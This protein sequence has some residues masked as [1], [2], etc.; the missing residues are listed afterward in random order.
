VT[1]VNSGVD[2]AAGGGAHAGGLP[3]RSQEAK[4]RKLV[5]ISTVK[6]DPSFV[7]ASRR[8]ELAMSSRGYR[9][10]CEEKEANSSDPHEKKVWQFM[11]VIFEKNARNQLLAHLGF[12]GEAVARQAAT[13][14]AGG[15]APPSTARPANG[16]ASN[17]GGG[18]VP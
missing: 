18:A 13:F 7:A 12:D 8:F 9:A 16:M 3:G 6:E 10:F 15:S 1:F 11:Q 5:R 2:A 14:V 17:A 4:G